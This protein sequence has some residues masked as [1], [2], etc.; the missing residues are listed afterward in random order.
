METTG[1]GSLSRIVTVATIGVPSRPPLGAERVT[2]RVSASS[3]STSSRRTTRAVCKEPL[4]A[5]AGKVRIAAVAVKS[6]PV[7][8]VRLA[9]AHLTVTGARVG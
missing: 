5:P 4:G 2:L 9:V 8:A 1:R 6:T 3:E 7:L